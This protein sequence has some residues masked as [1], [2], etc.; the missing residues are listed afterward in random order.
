[1]VKL[2]DGGAYLVNGTEIIPE[3]EGAKV[4]Q[5]TGKKA[6][7]K[8]ARKGTIAYG[9]M[10]AHNTAADMDNLKIKFDAMASHDI[11]FVGIIQTAKASGMEKFPIPYVLTNCHNSLCAVGGTT[12][13]TT[14]CS[15][16]PLQRNMVEST[17]HR[18]LRLFISTCVRC[19]QAVER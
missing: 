18:T 11:T 12:M 13:R 17:F 10:E 3:S 19:M 1:M 9:I 7:K 2:Y 8:E 16:F 5:L 15:V 4:E 14:T 6:D